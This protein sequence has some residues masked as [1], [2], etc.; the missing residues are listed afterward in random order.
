M[1]IQ[2][3]SPYPSLG[4]PQSSESRESAYGDGKVTPNSPAQPLPLPHEIPINESVL[5]EILKVYDI[6]EAEWDIDIV[7]QVQRMIGG[8]MAEFN[9]VDDGHLKRVVFRCI[10]S[11]YER[12]LF[13]RGLVII[14]LLM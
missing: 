12:A 7:R 8:K 5:R 14:F 6:E 4:L 9:N 2:I 1:S 3:S 11:A 13:R 10:S